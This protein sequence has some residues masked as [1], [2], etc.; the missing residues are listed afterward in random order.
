MDY[1]LVLENFESFISQ[2]S[3]QH[4]KSMCN[5]IVTDNANDESILAWRAM[6]E[7][8]ED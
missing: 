7:L 8:S 4:W 2:N 3:A 1:K 5:L 6:M